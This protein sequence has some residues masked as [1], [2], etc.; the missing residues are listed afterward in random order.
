MVSFLLSRENLYRAL[1]ARSGVN[2]STVI[3]VADAL[4]FK[5]MFKPARCEGRQPRWAR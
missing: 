4:G 2:F 5:M 3:N 1:S